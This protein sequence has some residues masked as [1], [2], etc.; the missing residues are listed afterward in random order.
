MKKIG[1]LTFHE[2]INHGGYFQAYAT[3]RTLENLGYDVSVIN[4]KNKKH[5][6]NEMRYFLVKKNPFEIFHNIKKIIAFKKDVN[7][8]DLYPK[9]LTHDKGKIDFSKFSHIVVGA[10]IVWNYQLPLLGHDSLYFGAGV[11]SDV[12]LIA[13]APSA[14]AVDI[15]KE[16]PSYVTKG[17]ASF[18]SITVRDHNTQNLVENITGKKPI[19]SLD[20]TF[21]YDFRG[22]E[23][24]TEYNNF[25]LIYAYSLRDNEIQQIQDFAR[26]NNKIVVAIAYSQPWADINVVNVS[27]FEW[28]GYFKKADFVVTST[29]H[30]TIFCIKYEKEFAISMNDAIKNKVQTLLDL[31]NLH[32]REITSITSVETILNTKASYEKANRVISEKVGFSYDY[33][34]EA[35]ND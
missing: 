27:P 10:D 3:Y 14:G 11:P 15:E 8:F 18:D 1:L 25:I 22:E 2:G 12:K 16:I 4:Y 31:F 20:P 35:I 9:K 17:I 28:L 32:D 33:F 30:G 24:E 23:I 29:F 21:L 5:H 34:K 7:K 6:I 19:I 13:H 26:K